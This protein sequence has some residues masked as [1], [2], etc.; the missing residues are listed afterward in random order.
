MES[1]AIDINDTLITGNS[2]QDV[3]YNAHIAGYTNMWDNVIKF[4]K[5]C[6]EYHIEKISSSY[7]SDLCNTELFR[8]KL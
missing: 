6:G 3:V 1:Y 2:I 7:V 4:R 5:R 8:A